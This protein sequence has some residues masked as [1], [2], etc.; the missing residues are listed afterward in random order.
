MSVWYILYCLIGN[1]FQK[2]LFKKFNKLNI[3]H[4]FFVQQGTKANVDANGGSS[5]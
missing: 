3:I 2:R 4:E 1:I 5:K